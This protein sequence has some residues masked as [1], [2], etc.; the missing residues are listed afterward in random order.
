VPCVL[1]ATV[2]GEAPFKAAP[3]DADDVEIFRSVIFVPPMMLNAGRPFAD[4][5]A[6]SL[7]GDVLGS[8]HVPA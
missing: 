5:A 4:S 3:V 6:V 2:E 8:S 7:P 1:Y